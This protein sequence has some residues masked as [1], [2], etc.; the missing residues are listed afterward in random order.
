MGFILHKAET[1]MVKQR[2]E[3]NKQT[4]FTTNCNQCH[5][6]LDGNLGEIECPFAINKKW[7]R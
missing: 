5:A 4:H 1:A 6:V 3:Q 2:N 7:I